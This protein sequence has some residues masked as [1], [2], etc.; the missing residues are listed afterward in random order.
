MLRWLARRFRSNRLFIVVSVILFVVVF[1]V[2]RRS[3]QQH[4]VDRY[5]VVSPTRN[6]VTATEPSRNNT[7]FSD[8]LADLKQELIRMKQVLCRDKSTRHSSND[9][10]MLGQRRRRWTNIETASGE[11]LIIAGLFIYLPSMQKYICVTWHYCM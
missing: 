7:V 2:K 1:H 5:N 6:I 3:A 4:A 11:C 8:R 9:V 10:S